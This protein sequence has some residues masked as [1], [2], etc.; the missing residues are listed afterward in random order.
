MLE[1]KRYQREALDALAL[2]FD[3]ARGATDEAALDAAFRQALLEQEIATDAIPPYLS[4]GFGTTPYVCI[5]IPTG[6]GKTLLGTHAVATA[7][8]HFTG[9]RCPLALWL[10][11]TNT[12]RQQTL[13]ALR[14]PGHP[15]REALE[16]HFGVDGLRVIDIA[17]CEQLRQQDF[18]AKTIVVVGTLQTL[19]VDD[20]S[21]RDVYAYKEAF[22]PH[23]ARA[24]E[25]PGF[26]RVEEKDLDAQ[27][28]LTRADLGKVKRSF[29]NLLYWHRPVVIIDEAHN[30]RTPLSYDSFARLRP[31]ALIEMTATPLRR[32]EHRSNVLY[33]VS[34]EELKAEQMIKLPIVLQAHPNW[35]EAV[36]D[37]LLTR[38]KLAAE[39]L[40]EPDYLRPILLLQAEDKAGEVTVDKLR[41]HL[42]EQEHVEAS[43]IAIA[44][45]S[46]RELDGID[47]FDPACRI[48]VVITV[49]ALK[50]GWDC[51]FA[52][53]FCSLQKVGSSRDMEQLLG[54]VLRMPYARRRQSELLNRAYAHVADART[55]EVANTLADRL[56]AMGFEELEAAQ[57]IFPTNLPLFE[58]D[59]TA[60]PPLP[61]LEWVLPET[62]AALAEGQPAPPGMSVEPRA[63]GGVT[64]RLSAPPTAEVRA[65]LMESVDKKQRQA[66][67]TALD[68]FELRHQ[69]LAAPSVRGI[70]FRPLPLL[71]IRDDQGELDLAEKTTLLHLA[72][73]ALAELPA[74]LPGFVPEQDR[75][76]YLLDIEAGHLRIEQ[77]QAAYAVNLDLV[78]TEVTEKDLVRWLSER[79]RDDDT[80]QT[81]LTAWLSKVLAWLERERGYTLTALVRHQNQLA[82]ALAERLKALRNKARYQGLQLA[83]LG[84]DPRGCVSA[85]FSFQFGR[86]MYPARPPYYRGRYRFLKHYYG[87]IG[88]LKGQGEEYDCAVAI[89]ELPE[90]KHWVR[91]LPR[92]PEFSFWLPTAT[93]RF[94]PDFVAELSDGRLLVVEYK[95]EDRKTSDDA[96]EKRQVGEFWAKE[97]GNLFLMAEAKDE[98]GR[99]VREQLRSLIGSGIFAEYERV[100]VLRD[101]EAEGYRVPAG[102][103]GNVVSVYGGGAAYAVEFED[104][105]DGMDVVTLPADV[106]ARLGK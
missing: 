26:E 2:F 32:G 106:L 82:D 17:E 81:Q 51:S 41:T 104:L 52:Y 80:M 50:E 20:T 8:R 69:E 90:V 44:T 97:T 13:T 59:G 93:D 98:A 77:E 73:F 33:H 53:V 95:G 101:V 63:E 4:Q 12:I 1:L 100:R 23:F 43:R 54:R 38:K 45:G 67:E 86:G 25:L 76:P 11:P 7:A 94:Y 75:K 40:A 92:F 46:Q 85:D 102:T 47:L 83:L 70:P 24:P 66:L 79:L 36:R 18:G 29:A 56:V 21:G 39:A 19:R 84:P 55:A 22:D 91:N 64:V 3:L 5:R 87:I 71:C 34:A 42:I 35:Q 96:R 31:A 37:A 99:G 89:D 9:E 10:V 16:K 27:P 48:E 88:D 103:E 78:A 68:R 65:V 14:T 105:G 60:L 58:D 72:G 74:D 49:E 57:A 15:Y 62:P 6:G 61:P 28:F 30:A